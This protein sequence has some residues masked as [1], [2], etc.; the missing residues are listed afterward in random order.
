MA[1]A[2]FEPATL[3][4]SGKHANHYTAE[5]TFLWLSISVADELS[6]QKVYIYNEWTIMDLCLQ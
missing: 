2:G 5:A 6:Q 1:S 4:S 3:G